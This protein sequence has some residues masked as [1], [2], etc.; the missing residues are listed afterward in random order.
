M[1]FE[2]PDPEK[3]RDKALELISTFTPRCAM[4]NT[5]LDNKAHETG[6]CGKCG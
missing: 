5:H 1:N 4:C 3:M 2:E 6:K